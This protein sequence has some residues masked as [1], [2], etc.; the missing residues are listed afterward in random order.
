MND[1]KIVVTGAT[2]FIG[3]NLLYELENRGYTN[4]V[5]IDRFGCGDKWKNV[6]KRVHTEFISPDHMWDFINEHITDIDAIVHLGGIS[7]TTE[8]DADLVMK[9]NYRMTVD[10]FEFCQRNKIRSI[11]ASS[12]ATYGNGE[13]GFNDID[14]YEHLGQLR[15]MNIYGWS[16]NQTDLYIS[17]HH[18]FAHSNTQV[19]GLKFFN[20]YGPNEYHK[21]SQRSIINTLYT[22]MKQTGVMRLFASS[23]EGINDG[24]QSRD[25][26]YID[27]CIDV[28][29]WMLEN[30]NISGL[31]NVGTGKA[32][33]FNEVARCVADSLNVDCKI[34]YFE[35]PNDIKEQY[36]NYTC[37]NIQ[38]LRDAGYCHDMMSIDKGI[39]NYV[40]EYLMKPDNYK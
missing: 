18:G 28:I 5:G 34:E 40:H 6:A 8:K 7:C 12:A 13:N 37:A 2:G 29:I 24:E 23:D 11:Y 31:F 17:T 21:S 3:S 15:P 32:A 22:Q 35:I 38:K 33:T 19:V 20:V 14:T 4:L 39:N 30:S 1:K 26:I 25:F 10:I 16:K 9:S 36:Q 27:D